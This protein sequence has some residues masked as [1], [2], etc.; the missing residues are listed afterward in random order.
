VVAALRP[1]APL[2]C[3][4]PATIAAAG[5]T[6]LGAFPGTVMYAV[7]CNPDPTVLRALWRGGIR[8]FDC[9]S[10]GEVRLV[11]SMF[12]D[13]EIHFMHPVKARGAIREAFAEHGRARLRA[14]QRGGAGPRSWRRRVARAEPHHPARP[15]E[16][17]RRL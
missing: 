9:A 4:R 5:A 16:G 2:H 15:A 7:K 14:R 6:F 13:A 1:E 10:A 8:H 12:P 17:Q 11:R 3:L